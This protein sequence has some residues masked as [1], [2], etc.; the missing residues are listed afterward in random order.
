MRKKI[1]GI[2]IPDCLMEKVELE[3]LQ[4]LFLALV[5]TVDINSQEWF[6][7]KLE[8]KLALG[9]MM[10]LIRYLGFR[11]SAPTYTLLAGIEN[12]FEEKRS[13]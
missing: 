12:F 10:L 11:R 8:L 7:L 2:F 6:A 4:A 5:G 13:H 3:K 1:E 9:L